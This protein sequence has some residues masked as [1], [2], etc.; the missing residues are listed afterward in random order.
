M[1]SNIERVQVAEGAMRAMGELWLD[2][3][4]PEANLTDIL[5]DLMHWAD[6]G[7][8]DFDDCLRIARGHFAYEAAEDS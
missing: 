3:Y 4:D 1:P 5:A 6:S 2:E 8:F 7:G